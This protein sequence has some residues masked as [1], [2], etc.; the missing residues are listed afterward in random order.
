MHPALLRPPPP[1][2]SPGLDQLPFELRE[3]TVSIK[4]PCGVVVSAQ[5]S[6]K[7]LNPA[8]ALP[9]ASSTFSR[10]RVDRA[11]RSSDRFVWRMA[12][13][14]GWGKSFVRASGL[15]PL[16]HSVEIFRNSNLRDL[17]RVSAT[18]VVLGPA[19]SLNASMG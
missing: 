11:S 15:Y 3:P 1:F 17:P 14:P 6:A 9:I 16:W 5:V 2:A 8:P 13:A 18:G 19:R 7:L 12:T 4:R 10:S